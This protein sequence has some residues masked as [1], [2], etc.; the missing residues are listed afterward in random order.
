[1]EFTFCLAIL[2]SRWRTVTSL[3]KRDPASA[4]VGATALYT[5]IGEDSEIIK[6]KAKR[7]GE[8]TALYAYIAHDSDLE[9]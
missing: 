1:M 9:D 3:E 6:K 8:A 2:I 4:D 5:Y 7:E